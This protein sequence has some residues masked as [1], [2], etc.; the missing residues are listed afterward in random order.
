MEPPMHYRLYGLSP[1]TGRIVQGRDVTAGSDAEAIA[2]GHAAYPEAPFEVWI[3]QRRV[4]SSLGD[5][6]AVAE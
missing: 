6:A 4:F 3:G 5:E 1:T 2:A